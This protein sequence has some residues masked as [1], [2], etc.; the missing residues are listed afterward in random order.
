[1]VGEMRTLRLLLFFSVLAAGV[2][3][4]VLVS[5]SPAGAH[6]AAFAHITC[7]AGYVSATIGGQPKCLRDGEFCS[8]QYEA[9]YE[10]YGFTCE[11]DG[12][13]GGYAGSSSTTTPT[14]TSAPPTTTI[15]IATIATTDTATIGT[16]TLSTT[17]AP[18][19]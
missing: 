13:L 5:S 8:P 4:A 15:P 16:T 2:M 10:R 12:R 14:T 19:T 7:S 17:T 1:M 6:S 18:T 3:A 9:D 11:A